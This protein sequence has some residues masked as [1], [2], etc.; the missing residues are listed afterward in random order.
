VLG[1]QLTGPLHQP[2]ISVNIA[3]DRALASRETSCSR[4]LRLYRADATNEDFTISRLSNQ[5]V[6]PNYRLNLDFPAHCI[7][8]S[9]TLVTSQKGLQLQFPIHKEEQQGE[10]EPYY[11]GSPLPLTFSI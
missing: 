3:W 8:Q 5:I 6:E 1:G 9:L 11:P 2:A 10:K 7:E 4:D